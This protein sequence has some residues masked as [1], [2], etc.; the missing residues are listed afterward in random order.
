[1]TMNQDNTPKIQQLVEQALGNLQPL[2][3]HG[4]GS[5]Q[6][7]LDEFNEALCID[8]RE[9]SGVIDYQPTE[10]TLKVRS[11]TSI[12]ALKPLLQQN[13]QRLP[14]DFPMYS[15]D[16]TIGGAIALGHSGSGRP[17]H[18]AIRDHVLGVT[19]INGLAQA[20]SGGGQVM[21]N[22]AGYD[23]SRLLCG[24]RGTL[25]PILDIT[26]KVLPQPE[27]QLTLTFEQDEASA[28]RSMN[29]M[30]GEALPIT[31]ACYYQQQLIIRLQGTESG[32]RHAEQKMGG[33][34]MSDD[35]QFWDSIQQQTHPFFANAESLWRIILPASTLPLELE[36]DHS[37][38]IDWCGG[39]RW[40]QC[41][42]IT[43]SDFMH[44][45]NIGGY[46]ESHKGAAPTQPATL[47]DTL[48]IKMHQKIKHAFD[49]HNLFNPKLSQ[50]ND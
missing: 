7:M 49:P 46:I 23:I 30:A 25:G 15:K 34:H 20:L 41:D 11:G 14:T 18:G 26:L 45:R 9:H 47:M 1:M 35:Q 40:L 10:L 4:S 50:F 22:V 3:I 43:Q 24:S 2:S 36:N 31:A 21:K 13:R 16:S 32:V 29:Q 38:F 5:H 42:T 17:F 28:I 27:T 8:M 48:Q 44:I 33:E 39:L 6:F 12:Q 37:S 19:I